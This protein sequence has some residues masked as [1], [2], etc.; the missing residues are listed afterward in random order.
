MATTVCVNL[1]KF[2]SI[3]KG[4]KFYDVSMDDIQPGLV[5]YCQLEPD[6]VHDSNCIARMVDSVGQLGHLT[7]EDASV[8]ASLL[9]EGLSARG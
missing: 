1:C 5:F 3:A 6:N 2:S 8:L 7:R 4:I 9:L